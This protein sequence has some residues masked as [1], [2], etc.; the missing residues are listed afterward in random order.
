VPN[1]QEILLR[2]VNAE[3]DGSGASGPFIPAVVLEGPGGVV[4]ARAADPS[5]VI[6]AGSSGE[7]SWF[8][9]VKNGGAAGGGIAAIAQGW[10]NNPSNGDPEVTVP[11]GAGYNVPWAHTYTSDSSY[12]GFATTTNTDDTIELAKANTLYLI[13]GAFAWESAGYPVQMSVAQGTFNTSG[14]FLRGS[15]IGGNESGASSF[16]VGFVTGLFRSEETALVYPPTVP[17]GAIM[18][19]QQ[20]SGIDKKGSAGSM[21]ALAFPV[22]F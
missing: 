3:F 18:Q 12:F 14:D 4:M 6:A 17:Y 9:G 20:D 13:F 16:N 22:G 19:V 15:M 5:I 1:A 2:S 11:T 10:F 21:V 7:V 8:P